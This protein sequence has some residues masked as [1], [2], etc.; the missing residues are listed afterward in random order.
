MSSQTPAVTSREPELL[1]QTVVVIGGSAG[2]GLATA[3]LARAAGAKVVLTGRDPDRLKQAAHEIDAAVHCRVRRHRHGR[4]RAV[5]PGPAVADRPRHG[6][7]RR[8]LLRAAGRDGFRAGPARPRKHLWLPMHV[9]RARGRQ[10]AP[11]GN[12]AVHGRDGRAPA[13]VGLA[14]IG[15]MTAAHARADRQPRPRARPDPRQPASPPASS[16]R[17][18]RPAARRRPRRAARGAAR[19]AADPSRRRPRRRRRARRA[20][21][22]QHRADR[23]RPTTST[24]ANSSP[25]TTTTHFSDV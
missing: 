25:E 12:A 6:H 16:T 24:A 9:A 14:L 13:R 11:R 23:A 10:G 19:D 15:A 8:P 20:P 21:H 5:L 22:D 18:C 2:I 4:A 1:G 3:Q 7:R 17:R